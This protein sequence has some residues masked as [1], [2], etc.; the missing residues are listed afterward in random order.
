M[1]QTTC[2]FAVNKCAFFKVAVFTHSQ[3]LSEYIVYKRALFYDAVFD[4]KKDTY[5]TPFRIEDAQYAT[6]SP[7]ITAHKVGV[8][9]EKR[10]KIPVGMKCPIHYAAIFR[11]MDTSFNIIG[12]GFERTAL[13][14]LELTKVII[15][16]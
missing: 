4:T 13:V 9:N 2:K 10:C 14:E 16:R 7:L 8:L 3:T 6:P 12:C 5:F 11:E 1:A 15:R